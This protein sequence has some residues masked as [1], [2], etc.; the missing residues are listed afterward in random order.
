MG[1]KRMKIVLEE[2]I[3]GC[4]LTERRCICIYDTDGDL[5][6]SYW[7]SETDNPY[8]A[9]EITKALLES[10]IRRFGWSK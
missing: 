5:I 1:T 6:A 10:C 3:E 9:M 8:K 2:E 7:L 4:G